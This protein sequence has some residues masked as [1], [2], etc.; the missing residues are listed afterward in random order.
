MSEKYKNLKV[1][2]LQELL[3]KNNL[4]HSG[5]KEELI[6][7]LVR[8]DEKTELENLEKEFELDSDFDDSK[9]NLNDIPPD[10]FAPIPLDKQGTDVLDDIKK[11]ETR[12]SK[13]SDTTTRKTNSSLPA[14]AAAK[15]DDNKN[16]T[17]TMIKKSTFKYTP[18]TFDKK[19]SM[20]DKV[21][22]T[23]TTTKNKSS[24]NTNKSNTAT[25]TAASAATTTVKNA[26]EPPPTPVNKNLKD[27]VAE[28][29]RLEAERRLERSKRFGVKLDEDEMR[30]IRA[31]RFGISLP[32]KKGNPTTTDEKKKSKIPVAVKESNNQDK[33]K[34]RAE[35]FGISKEDQNKNKKKPFI[36][37][38]KQGRVLINKNGKKTVDAQPTN[39]NNKKKALNITQLP[40]T[41][42]NKKIVQTTTQSVSKG[43]GRTVTIQSSV[44]KPTISSL[45]KQ[46]SINKNGRNVIIRSAPSNDARTVT[47]AS[48]KNSNRKRGRGVEPP[49][50]QQKSTKRRRY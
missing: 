34:K 18:I 50:P 42:N 14:V 21:S 45:N 12:K 49:Q 17:T 27:P 5:K 11:D 29:L 36:N 4:S 7:R 3:Q 22:K 48:N 44:S 43:N 41:K 38:V 6:E 28:K 33:L 10:I 16:N 1:K 37:K 39:K 31:A 40:S 9:I 2:E 32:D 25:A 46:K 8:H 20:T 35:R 26:P 23:A 47:I 15:K 19:N 13:E 24:N 30:K